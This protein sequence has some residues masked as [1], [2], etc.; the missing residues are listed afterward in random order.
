MAMT[1]DKGQQEPSMEEILST[2]RRVI[3]DDGQREGEDAPA[4]MTAEPGPSFKQGPEDDDVL[5]LTEI[6]EEEPNSDL[7]LEERS[8]EKEEESM[9]SLGEGL[10]LRLRDIS[11]ITV[12]RLATKIMRP[13][14]RDWLDRN[15]P[16]MVENLVR[17]EIRCISDK[18][19]R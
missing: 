18:V 12:E 7:I 15:L 9:S 14:L 13:M 3:S 17:A 16:D 11:D 8:S 1:E 4:E 2:I 10:E 19:K 6:V 5:E